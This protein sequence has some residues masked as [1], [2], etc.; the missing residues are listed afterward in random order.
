MP[1]KVW[2]IGG[3]SVLLEGETLPEFEETLSKG[4]TVR[5]HQEG[6]VIALDK[7]TH[8]EDPDAMPE[9]ETSDWPG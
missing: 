4:G 2:F 8:A 1:V 7:V 3:E 9:V 5:Y 6:V